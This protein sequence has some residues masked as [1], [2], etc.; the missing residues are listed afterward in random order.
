MLGDLRRLAEDRG[1][2]DG[3]IRRYTTLLLSEID[4]HHSNEDDLLWP[5]IERTAGQ[6]VD[7]AFFTD[8]HIALETILTRCRAVLAKDLTQLRKALGELHE[9]LAE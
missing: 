4:H 5:V 3:A 6:A 7:L 1:G 8:D 9:M 2:Q